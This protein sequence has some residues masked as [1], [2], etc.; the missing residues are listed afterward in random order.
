M[1]QKNALCLGE[2]RVFLLK[3]R[4]ERNQQKKQKNK[5]KNK[6]KKQIRRV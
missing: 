1:K 2:T 3:Q 4:K 5:K 6:Q